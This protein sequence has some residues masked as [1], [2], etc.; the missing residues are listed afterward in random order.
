MIGV[1]CWMSVACAPK[2]P[3][4]INGVRNYN[5]TFLC[6]GTKIVKVRFTPFAAALESD[7]ASADLTQQPTADGFL[8]TGGGQSLHARANEA[9]WSDGK[10][11]THQC[12]ERLAG[13]PKIDPP[14]R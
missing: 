2:M 12:R 5:A 7:G 3:Q 4:A 8:Y 10:G 1:A 14:P 13:S 9:T 11:A 6:D